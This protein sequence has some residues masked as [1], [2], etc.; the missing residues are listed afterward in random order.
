MHSSGKLYQ[1]KFK[2]EKEFARN[3]RGRNLLSYQRLLREWKFVSA[4]TSLTLRAL[5]LPLR[6]IRPEACRLPHPDFE[7]AD[8][9]GPGRS[10]TRPSKM[11]TTAQ[12]ED[13]FSHFEALSRASS[14]TNAVLLNVSKA[15]QDP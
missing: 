1:L 9:A 7:N 4:F 5:Q 8:S 14:T 15:G 13:H 2:W 12:D 11:K 3:F 10:T 6:V